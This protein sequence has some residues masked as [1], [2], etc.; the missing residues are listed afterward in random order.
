MSALGQ[1][2]LV[3]AEVAELSVFHYWSPNVEG[4]QLENA[5]TG[6]KNC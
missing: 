4:N 6:E 5:F 1:G 2:L 3:A